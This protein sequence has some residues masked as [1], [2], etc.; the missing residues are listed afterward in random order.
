M[1]I[2]RSPPLSQHEKLSQVVKSVISGK[3]TS[4][5]KI[6]PQQVTYL[7]CRDLLYRCGLPNLLASTMRLYFTKSLHE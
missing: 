1:H 4:Q 7:C 3:N 5:K 2:L 6:I